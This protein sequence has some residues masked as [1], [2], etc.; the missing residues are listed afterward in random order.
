MFK[1]TYVCSQ[2]FVCLAAVRAYL[3]NAMSKFPHIQ[4]RLLIELPE[5]L[6]QNRR[7][8]LDMR[9]LQHPHR[10]I[11]NLYIYIYTA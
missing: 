3:S 10:I 1:H 9:Y 6:L 7:D 5:F 4:L 2:L 11:Q 8:Q